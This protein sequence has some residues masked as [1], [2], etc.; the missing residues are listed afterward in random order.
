FNNQ[1]NYDRQTLMQMPGDEQ[2][3]KGRGIIIGIIIAIVLIVGMLFV[4]SKII[5]SRE[6]SKAANAKTVYDAAY[7]YQTELIE[8]NLL[9]NYKDADIIVKALNDESSAYSPGLKIEATRHP[10]S[11]TY[12]LEVD[13]ETGIITVYWASAADDSV[14]FSYPYDKSKII[15]SR[16]VSK[17]A[18]AQN[19]YNAAYAYQTELI[20]MNKDYKDTDI[21]VEAINDESSTFSPG[22][23]IEATRHPSSETYGLEVD[24]ET[25][26]M[27]IYWT[28]AADDSVIFSYPYDK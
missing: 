11:E 25:G 4:W 17:A 15:E 13:K 16:E 21:I 23:K 1:M 22:L 20:G 19:V 8:Q 2:K 27:T 24:E 26:K 5:E 7:A 9:T 12:G 18:N 28:S 6:V 3:K 14:I 10:S